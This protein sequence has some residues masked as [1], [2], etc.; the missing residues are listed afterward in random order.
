[1][2]APLSVYIDLT[3]VVLLVRFV[4]LSSPFL[5]PVYDAC[6]DCILGANASTRKGL[7]ADQSVQEEKTLDSTTGTGS[8]DISFAPFKSLR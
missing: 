3:Y 8:K 4:G 6:P 5:A 1:M 2:S 7:K